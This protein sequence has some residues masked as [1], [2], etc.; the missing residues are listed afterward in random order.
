MATKDALLSYFRTMI[1]ALEECPEERT[2]M[3]NNGPSLSL[4][5]SSLGKYPDRVE[6]EPQFLTCCFTLLER[7]SPQIVVCI[8]GVD[9]F[10]TR[11]RGDYLVS[12]QVVELVGK[13]DSRK[14]GF[15]RGSQILGRYSPTIRQGV[16]WELRP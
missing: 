11:H 5:G 6:G 15:R 14:R 4:L 10:S 3:A 2:V 7:E 8:S 1:R 12:G 9:E 16:F 13:H